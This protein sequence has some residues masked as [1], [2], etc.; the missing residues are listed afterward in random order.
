MLLT[1]RQ[2]FKKLS[3]ML[4]LATGLNGLKAQESP[5]AA[6][7][8][9]AGSGGSAS[10]SIGQ[11]AYSANPGPNGSVAQGVQQPYEISVI[12]ATIEAGGIELIVSAYPNPTTDI[13]M[14]RINSA[15]LVTFRKLGYKLSDI[16]GKLLEAKRIEGTQTVI[17]LNHRTPG[18]YLLSIAEENTDL[19]TFKI[20]K[21]R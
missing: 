20:I 3:F 5:A 12:T 21:A 8:D 16:N 18:T 6:G 13:L 9:A 19:K 4:L 10:Y 15:A 1:M 7:G 14:I 11:V 17:V 2:T